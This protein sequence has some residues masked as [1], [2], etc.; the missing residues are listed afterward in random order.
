MQKMCEFQ[1]NYLLDDGTIV[2]TKGVVR[3]RECSGAEDEQYLVR[4]MEFRGAHYGRMCLECTSTKQRPIYHKKDIHDG[5]PTVC[6]YGNNVGAK[7]ARRSKLP[8]VPKNNPR[9]KKAARGADVAKK[10][11]K[12]TKKARKSTK[13]STPQ[14]GKKAKAK[15]KKAKPDIPSV[16]SG[17]RMTE[18]ANTWKDAH[19]ADTLRAADSHDGTDDD[20]ATDADNAVDVDA[21]DADDAAG[22]ADVDA[23]DTPD[24]NDADADAGADGDADDDDDDDDADY[25]DEDADLE[26][27]D[28]DTEN[29][30]DKDVKSGMEDDANDSGDADD[31]DEDDQVGIVKG[32]T[33]N[34]WDCSVDPPMCLY[35]LRWQG[36]NAKGDTFH[37]AE[38]CPPHML[39]AFKKTRKYEPLKA[40]LKRHLKQATKGKKRGR[41]PK[42]SNP[43][44]P[45]A[46][47][48]YETRC[49][50]TRGRN[51][52]E[53]AKIRP[54]NMDTPPTQKR[55]YTKKSSA[56]IAPTR[57]SLRNAKPGGSSQ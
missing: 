45:T 27:G 26:E 23:P 50:A 8:K 33:G 11:R 15:I 48:E 51:A 36:H 6:P 57:M 30:N 52:A 9:A 37:E 29:A 21:V 46:P 25:E 4:D 16:Q 53:L 54:I 31:D 55:K 13:K 2:W 20:N 44:T 40:F 43:P 12:S 1:Y 10:A 39:A 38:S 42:P 22:G 24:A 41:P 14:K 18:F 56:P 34:M 19:D 7:G 32:I 17:L 3:M 35:V 47:N 49:L 5:K 28:D